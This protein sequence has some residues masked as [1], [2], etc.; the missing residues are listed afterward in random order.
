MAQKKITEL[1]LI[2]AIAGD[3]N[4]PL[5]DGIQTYR[6]TMTQVAAYVAPVY[7][8]PSFASYVSG[9]G[10]HYKHYTFI[11][12]SASATIGATYTN[13]SITYTVV[14]TIASKTQIVLSG[15]GAPSASGTLTKA[16]GTGD[17]SITFTSVRVPIGME[18]QMIGGGGGGGGSSTSAANNGGIGGTGGDTTFGSSTASG[19]LPGRGQS[20]DSGGGG[21]AISIGIGADIGSFVGS[22]GQGSQES[23]VAGVNLGGRMG[24]SSPFAGGGPGAPSAAGTPPAGAANSGV[25]GG[26]AGAPA[27]GIAGSGGG[28]GGYIKAYIHQNEL[29]DSMAYSIGAAGTAGASGTSGSTGGAGAAGRIIIRYDF[30]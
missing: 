29:L 2:S 14:K 16:S 10:T 22:A 21:G 13:N 26:G 27:T 30:Q 19:G 8:P 28:A 25:G 3:E 11:C 9:S 24:A 18:Y 1:Q 5:D 20:Q 15:S 4:F 23:N 12:A 6:A 7:I 17:S